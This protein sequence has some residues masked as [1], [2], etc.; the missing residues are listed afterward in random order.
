MTSAPSRRSSSPSPRYAATPR[1]PPW[2]RPARPWAPGPPSGSN[3][4]G[5]PPPDPPRP[6]GSTACVLGLAGLLCYLVVQPR[7]RR[8]P[9]IEALAILESD[10]KAEFERAEDLLRRVLESAV[11]RRDLAEARFART[12]A[13]ARL[14]R[15]RAAAGTD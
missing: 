4:T 11:R 14:G 15:Y 13:L 8:R 7:R 6:A 5:T 3:G 10:R 1:P 12:Y 9:L 2:C